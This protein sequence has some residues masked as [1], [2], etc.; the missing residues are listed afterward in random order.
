MAFGKCKHS[1]DILC[2]VYCRYAKKHFG[3]GNEQ[4]MKE[5]QMAMGLLAFSPATKCKRYQVSSCNQ[6][7][8]SLLGSS[9]L[10]SSLLR[11][12][13]YLHCRSCSRPLDGMSSFCCS[14]KRTSA[15]SNSV[16]TP[17]SP[18]CCR[19]GSQHSRLRI[20]TLDLP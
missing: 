2:M 7:S 1:C 16:P 12:P 4:F 14:G 17:S 19:L 5:I 13:L 8:M 11:P 18:V 15:C 10:L 9:F 6:G 3:S 20:P